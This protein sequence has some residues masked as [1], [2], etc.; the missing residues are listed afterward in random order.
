M[1]TKIALLSLLSVV[2]AA[3]DTVGQGL[4]TYTFEDYVVEFAKTYTSKEERESRS[5]IFHKAKKSVIE[6]NSGKHSY[7]MAINQFSDLTPTEFSGRHGWVNPKGLQENLDSSFLSSEGKTVLPL[8][9]S[10]LF[11]RATTQRCLHCPNVALLFFPNFVPPLPT[12]ELNIPSDFQLSDLPKTVDW[13]T[14]G[15]VTAVKNQ[16]MCGSCWAFSSTENIESHVAIHANLTAAP[17]LSPQNLISC[18]PN[19]NDCG[20]DGG[21]RGSVPELA[22]DYVK[23]NGLASEADWPYV[24]GHTSVNEACNNTAKPAAHITGY[25]K[26]KANNY[27][28]VMYTLANRG[29]V[30]VNV[31]AIPMQSYGGGLMTGCASDSTHIDHVVQL[32]GY[33]FDDDA[34]KPYWIMR[35]SWGTTWGISGYMHLERHLPKDGAYCGLDIKPLDGTGCTGGPGTLEVCGSCGVLWDVSYPI[36]GSVGAK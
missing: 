6:H 15:V 36:G 28:E 25:V 24:S 19:P 22:F 8:T 34:E 13:R 12:P 2:N 4:D 20:G 21:C 7:S 11:G 31:D 18:D 3:P 9:V 26:L 17:V 23:T 35:N 29:P 10:G 33:G 30:A 5:Q 1:S 14:K 27:T 16:G 32:V